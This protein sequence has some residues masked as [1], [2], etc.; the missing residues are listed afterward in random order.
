MAIRAPEQRVKRKEV[1]PPRVET[2]IMV[3]KSCSDYLLL[4]QLDYQ[5]LI[6]SSHHRFS[7]SAVELN[8]GT[9]IGNRTVE[10]ERAETP[11]AEAVLKLLRLGPCSQTY[12][13]T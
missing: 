3:P 1:L 10:G 2:K 5:Y 9:G 7:I 12:S 6:E 13:G 4:F 11:P 8:R